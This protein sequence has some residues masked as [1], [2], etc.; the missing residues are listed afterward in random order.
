MKHSDISDE[1]IQD[2]IKGEIHFWNKTQGELSA[3]EGRL[4]A[5][6]IHAGLRRM[7]MV[8]KGECR[9]KVDHHE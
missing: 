4:F 2:F 1:I 3:W 8:L 9:N 6:G 7:E 5:A